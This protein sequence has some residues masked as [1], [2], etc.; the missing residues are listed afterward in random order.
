MKITKLLLLGGLLTTSLLGFSQPTPAVMQVGRQY[1]IQSAMNYG[2]N[3]GG[4]WDLPGNPQ[5]IDKGSNIAVWDLDGGIDRKFTLV[6]SQ[7]QGYYEIFVGDTR[8]SRVDIENGSAKDGTNVKVWEKN[9]ATAQRFLFHHLGNG[10]FKIFDRNGKVICLAGRSNSNGTNVHIWG[11]HDGVWMEWYLIDAQTKTA[12]IPSQTQQ[13]S[14]AP[15]RG[16]AV[17]QGKNYWIQSAM[18]Y[19]RTPDGCWDLPGDNGTAQNANIQ[20]WTIDN[21]TDRFFRFEKKR[22]SEFY[23]IYAGKTSDGVVDLPGGKTDNGN[24]MQIWKA[25]DGN[26]NQ[27]FYLKHLGNGRF[28]IYHKSGKIIN[29]KNTDNK[30]GNKVQL[31]NDH[32]G[33]HCEWYLVDPATKQAYIPGSGNVASQ[34]AERPAP[35]NNR[36]TSNT[37]TRKL[38]EILRSGNQ[39]SIESFFS[40]VSIDAITGSESGAIVEVLNSLAAPEQA[41]HTTFILNGLRSNQNSAVRSA[42]YNQLLQ[43]E[44]KK[45]AFL[46]KAMMNTYFGK[47]QEKDPSL[48]NLV[49]A[50]QEKIVK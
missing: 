40:K 26:P 33:I 13:V 14:E 48:T 31:W 42:S 47:Y 38:S 4:Y 27:D 10:R 15:L 35:A 7:E 39:P 41:S 24:V 28:K 25:I 23:Q 5:M 49:T 43:V 6:N 34:P 22:N 29:L 19:G 30:N 1:Y 8:A 45:M 11:D 3:Y 16:D 36:P 32:D 18:S 17:P 50:L 37:D 12:F 20:I 2:R 46:Y 9:G 44:Y 21:G